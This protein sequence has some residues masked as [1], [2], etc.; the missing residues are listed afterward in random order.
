VAGISP[1]TISAVAIVATLN[2][3]LALLTMAS[4]ILYGMSKLGDLP[5]IFGHVY[6]RTSTPLIATS[7]VAI[8]VL[9]FALLVPFER[10][11]E[12][13][14]LATLLVFAL[15]NLALI[16]LRL[17]ETAPSTGH[18]RVPLWV[19]TVGLVVCL[20]MMAASFV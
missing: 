4:R 11:A 19:P 3:V 12:W 9:T 13:T 2:T 15:V 17:R 5:R 1:T 16:R 14:S 10:L 18:F 8:L 7:V 6:H 20:L